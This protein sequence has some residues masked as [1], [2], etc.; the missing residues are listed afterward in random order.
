MHSGTVMPMFPTD[1]P[2]SD[3]AINVRYSVNPVMLLRIF[4]RSPERKANG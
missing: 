4:P 2:G 1:E 3:A